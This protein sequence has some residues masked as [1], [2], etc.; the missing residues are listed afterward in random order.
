MRSLVWGAAAASAVAGVWLALHAAGAVD[1]AGRELA[2]KRSEL[3][4]LRAVAGELARSAAAKAVFEGEPGRR[5]AAVAALLD[6]VLPG[7][8]PEDSRER[9][10]EIAG[11]WLVREHE[12]AFG[13]VPLGKVMDFAAKAEAQRP[14]WKVTKCVI[15]ASPHAPG[16]GRVALVL[17]ALEKAGEAVPGPARSRGGT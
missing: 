1:R 12:F 16:T 5:P 9:R 8:K 10:R 7:V 11:G 3:D 4:E 15:R 2:R 14:P 13:E 17:E 6:E